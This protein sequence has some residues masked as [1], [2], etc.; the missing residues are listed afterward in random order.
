MKQVYIIWND[1]W[2]P[3]KDIEPAVSEIFKG[4]DWETVKTERARDLL[5]PGVSPDLAIFYTNGRPAGETD[6]TNEEQK[7]IADKVEAGMGILFI[8]AG[9]TIIEPDSVF[10]Q[11]L[12]SGRFVSHPPKCDVTMTPVAG[13]NHPILEGIA[14]FTNFDEHYYCPMFPDRTQVLMCAS[15]ENS[16]TAGMWCHSFGKGRVAS[17]TQGHTLEMQ[18]DPEMVKL[19][20]NAACW[21]TGQE[22]GDTV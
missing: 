17:I 10:Y 8:H 6:L 9:L 15:S 1:G 16:V 11:E 5:E 18:T 21:L 14:P 2:H 3:Q 20:R 12:N 22:K 13:L 19:V 7:K 4:D